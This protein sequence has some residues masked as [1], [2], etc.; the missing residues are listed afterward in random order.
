M[1]INVEANT[2]IPQE[3]K[4][5]SSSQNCTILQRRVKEILIM[6]VVLMISLCT[7]VGLYVRQL[8]QVLMRYQIYCLLRKF[9]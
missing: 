6:C 9:P 8:T 5:K 1:M 3:Q 2:F 4:S 7:S